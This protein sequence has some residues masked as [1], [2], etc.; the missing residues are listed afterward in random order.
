MD[1]SVWIVKKD[2]TKK[3]NQKRCSVPVKAKKKERNTGSYKLSR[4]FIVCFSELEKNG[5]FHQSLFF[6]DLHS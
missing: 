6:N 5:H 1:Y 3:Y 4:V 2:E